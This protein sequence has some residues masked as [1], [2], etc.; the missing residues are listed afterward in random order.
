MVGKNMCGMGSSQF[1]IQHL[2]CHTD[3]ELEK[4]SHR[5]MP[6]LKDMLLICFKTK[7]K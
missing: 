7:D 5:K 2:I 3:A 6:L 1:F 4:L